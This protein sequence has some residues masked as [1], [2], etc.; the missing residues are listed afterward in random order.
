MANNYPFIDGNAAQK[1]KAATEITTGVFADQVVPVNATGTSGTGGDVAHDA[2]DSGNPVKIGGK[3]NTTLPAAVSNADR[4]DAWFGTSG[5]FI[6]GVGTTGGDA[7]VSGHGQLYTP[8][9]TAVGLT[10]G[11]VLFNG[12]TSDRER[13]NHEVTVL[14]SA[15]RTALVNSADLVNYNARGVIVTIDATAL[16]ATPGVTFTIKGKCTLS[17][18]YYTILAS[19]AVTGV[20]TTTLI[21]YPGATVAANLAVSQP[22]PRIWRVEVTVA[23]A[24]SLTYSVSANYI[25]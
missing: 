6:M 23:D 9:G 7:Q 15:A 17:G 25:N 19:A 14:A 1:I 10:V 3:A 13:C 11:P 16:A 20:S 5:Q 22:L 18:K 4:V 12:S 2:V 21:V 8:G 24:D